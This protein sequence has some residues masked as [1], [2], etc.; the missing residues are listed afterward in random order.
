[1]TPL[2]WD[3]L[4]DA[5]DQAQEASR[6][7][8]PGAERAALERLTLAR[9]A[10]GSLG[11]LLLVLALDHA[12]IAV[13]KKLQ[14]AFGGVAG[15]ALERAKRA[16]ERATV[17]LEELAAV[18]DRLRALEREADSRTPGVGDPGLRIFGG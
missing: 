1:M 7:G 11:G 15:A 13:Q 2:P 9:E 12:G 5:L 17:A 3:E 4:A 6:S 14:K 16:E 18:R 8:D 10:C